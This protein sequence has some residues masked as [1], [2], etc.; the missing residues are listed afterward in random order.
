MQ[1]IRI[2]KI[3]EEIE[4]LCDNIENLLIATDAGE[5][6]YLTK[7]EYLL[8]ATTDLELID[9]T[10]NDDEIWETEEGLQKIEKKMVEIKKILTLLAPKPE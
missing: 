4:N 1:E 2:E 8:L 10:F 6:D 5:I 3:L 7:E 9:F